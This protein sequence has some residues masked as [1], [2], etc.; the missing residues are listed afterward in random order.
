MFSFVH[1]SLPDRY[2]SLD[3]WVTGWFVGSQD[4]TLLFQ[5]NAEMRANGGFL[6]SGLNVR[7]F[8]GLPYHI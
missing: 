8:F 5:N 3:T 2:Q 6:S 1:L 4:V 7:L